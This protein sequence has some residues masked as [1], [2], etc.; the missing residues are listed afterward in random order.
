MGE[1]RERKIKMI[2]RRRRTTKAY[3]IQAQ[4]MERRGESVGRYI[5]KGRRGRV[6]Q[7]CEGKDQKE[8]RETRQCKYL[9]RNKR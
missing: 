5:L 9:R 8:R 6:G 7:E 4:E 1:I 3:V 2:L